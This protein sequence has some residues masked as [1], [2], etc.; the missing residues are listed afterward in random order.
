MNA[1]ISILSDVVTVAL[2]T[3]VMLIIVILAIELT[4]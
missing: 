2:A 1:Y 4:K 3:A